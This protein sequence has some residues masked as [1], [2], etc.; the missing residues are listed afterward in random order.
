MIEY[1]N[2]VV[3]FNHQSR[4]DVV[5]LSAMDNRMLS[6]A[7]R[8]EVKAVENK[9]GRERGQVEENEDMSIE[10]MVREERRTRGQAGGEGLLLAE[11]IAKDGKFDNDLE[12]M[13]EN[14]S[15]LAKR[16]QKSDINLRNMA[17]SDFQK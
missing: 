3:A 9:R 10:D 12:Y 13:D 17:I 2:A 16:V 1:N 7:P 14:A 5:T 6:S 8:N 11:R 15:K 4:P